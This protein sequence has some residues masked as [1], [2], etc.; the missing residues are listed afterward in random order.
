MVR[1]PNQRAAEAAAIISDTV[2]CLAV[3]ASP[4]VAGKLPAM[5]SHA[6]LLDVMDAYLQGLDSFGSATQASGARLRETTEL[7]AR[8][9]RS[10]LERWTPSPAVPMD[11]QEAARALM[12]ALGFPAPPEGWDDFEG[13]HDPSQT[14]NDNGKRRVKRDAADA[15]D[16]S[17]GDFNFFVQIIFTLGSPKRLAHLEALPTREEITQALE[18]FAKYAATVGPIGIGEGFQ[19][20]VVLGRQLLSRLR[21]WTP[22]EVPR[23]VTLEARAIM[24]TMFPAPADK[25]ADDWTKQER[26]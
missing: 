9:L 25:W 7:H 19:R 10:L 22:S 4:K 21:D 16:P 3:L 6:S 20:A 14:G 5:P 12:G 11:I 26:A 8:H 1:D 18:G 13:P 24:E 23:D 17:G 2:N 15:N